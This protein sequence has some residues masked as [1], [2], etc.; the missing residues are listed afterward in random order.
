MATDN[1]Y[2]FRN[3]TGDAFLKLL[4][5][6]GANTPASDSAVAWYTKFIDIESRDNVRLRTLSLMIDVPSRISSAFGVGRSTVTLSAN[7]V[8]WWDH[9][10]CTDPNSTWGGADSYGTYESVLT[11]PSPRTYRLLIRT[12]F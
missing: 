12:R 2:R 9:C 11:D 6:N 3:H 7:N 4:G 1:N 10:H 8:M 5:P